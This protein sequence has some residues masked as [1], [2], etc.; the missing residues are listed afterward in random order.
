M[1]VHEIIYKQLGSGRFVAMTGAT[2]LGYDADS[3][4]FRIKGSKK[5]NHVKVALNS[6]DLYDVTYSKIWGHKSKTVL[7]SSGLYCDMLTN[8]IEQTTGLY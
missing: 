2:Q 7:E 5:V 1:K 8:D 4:S 6:M 3:L